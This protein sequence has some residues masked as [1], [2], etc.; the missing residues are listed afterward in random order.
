[1]KLLYPE[2]TAS[3]ERVAPDWCDY[4]LLMQWR[5]HNYSVPNAAV[6]PDQT[7]RVNGL[8][9]CVRPLHSNE[10]KSAKNFLLRFKRAEFTKFIIDEAVFT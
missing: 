7:I 3:I 8:E 4:A 2:E 9:H 6:A 1:M 10:T 5:L